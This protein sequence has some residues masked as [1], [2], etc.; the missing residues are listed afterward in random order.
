MPSFMPS[1]FASGVPEYPAV[2]LNL[3]SFALSFRGNYMF[4]NV[5][6][7]NELDIEK[8]NGSSVT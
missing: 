3:L 6:N 4:K 5:S 2:K 8:E 7:S 1:F